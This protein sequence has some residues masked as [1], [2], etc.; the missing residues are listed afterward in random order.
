MSLPDLRRL[1]DVELQTL[2]R[3]VRLARSDADALEAATP[4]Q[5]DR[6]ARVAPPRARGPG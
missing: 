1:P 5:P 3:R 4:V 2:I 6:Q